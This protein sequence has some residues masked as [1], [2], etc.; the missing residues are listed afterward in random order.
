MCPLTSAT[1]NLSPSLTFPEHHPSGILSL[2]AS[3]LPYPDSSRG[4]QPPPSPRPAPSPS[5]SLSQASPS[6]LP[7]VSFWSLL[8]TLGQLS[9]ASP[10]ESVSEFCWSLLGNSRQLSWGGRQSQ[11]SLE[12]LATLHHPCPCT[13]VYSR[14]SCDGPLVWRNPTHPTSHVVHLILGTRLMPP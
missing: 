13:L 10:N 7:S 8:G 14:H 6:P 12:P 5:T 3:L 9:Q 11:A 2:P 4:S 1:G